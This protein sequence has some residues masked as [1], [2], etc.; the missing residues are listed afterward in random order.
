MFGTIIN[1]YSKRLFHSIFCTFLPTLGTPPT[2][3]APCFLNKPAIT[4][5]VGYQTFAQNAK[6]TYQLKSVQF[7]G[8]N[9]TFNLKDLTGDLEGPAYDEDFNFTSTAPMLQIRVGNGYEPYYF[10]SDGAVDAKGDYVPGWA[11]VGGNPLP[12]DGVEIP[13]GTAFW[14]VDQYRAS[15][16]ITTA[17]A[18]VS[19][20]TSEITFNAGYTLAACPYPTAVAFSEISFEGLQGPAYD[21]DFNFT[22]T[23]PMIQVRVGNGYEP[24]Y[25]LSDGAVDAKGD[26]VPGWADVGGNPLP[27]YDA[28]VISVGTAFWMI[29]PTGSTSV[30]ATFAL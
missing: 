23:A 9:A 25:F 7:D 13:A 3:A 20:A 19:D 2:I 6:N 27:D 1:T 10:L 26:Y 30:K 11:D 22:A 14:F 16:S 17:G 28:K 4:N 18:V 5:I 8:V 24:Y 21:E 12:E 15:S 29:L